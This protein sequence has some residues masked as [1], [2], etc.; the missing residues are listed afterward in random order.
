MCRVN[1][2]GETAPPLDK[3]PHYNN[4]NNFFFFAYLFVFTFRFV[5]IKDLEVRTFFPTHSL[6]FAGHPTKTS[7]HFSW[8]ED[9]GGRDEVGLVGVLKDEKNY[10]NKSF[11]LREHQRDKMITFTF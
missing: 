7:D 8:V 5:R 2:R 1:I 4:N 3:R 10:L 9:D 6:W 11:H